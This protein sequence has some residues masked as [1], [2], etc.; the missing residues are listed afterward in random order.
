M[1]QPYIGEIR[2]FGGNFAPL[3]WAICDGRQLSISE[4]T[5]LF[6][7][8]GTTYGG[9]GQQSFNVPDLRGRVPVHQGNGFN[10]GQPAGSE[11]ISLTGTQLPAHSHALLGGVGGILSAS[12]I[13]NLPGTISPPAANL[14]ATL[15]SGMANFSGSA[16]TPAG[17]LPHEN[18]QPYLAI[19]FIIALEGIYP[20]PS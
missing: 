5:T 19:S 16:I 20:S 2:M 18:R 11:S 15:A 8:I 6:T 14:Y 9:D 3:G 10:I 1:A 13:N 12:P 7:L 17:A 4:Y